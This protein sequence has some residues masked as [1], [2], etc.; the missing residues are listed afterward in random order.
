MFTSLTSQSA[1]P[2]EAVEAQRAIKGL[3]AATK[4]KPIHLR[5]QRDRMQA[6][7]SN[8]KPTHKNSRKIESVQ[9]PHQAF[10]SAPPL[11]Y[12]DT[13]PQH[14]WRQV[15]LQGRVSCCG[16]IVSSSTL[17]LFSC[18]N[19]HCFIVLLGQNVLS[20][21]TWDGRLAV[22]LLVKEAQ[23]GQCLVDGQ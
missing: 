13:P 2:T 8:P 21:S 22:P 7:Y 4:T 11:S 14:L 18:W 12:S 19:W 10:W 20:W 16:R 6:T 9:E 23:G 17:S 3:A 5:P 15:I 1:L